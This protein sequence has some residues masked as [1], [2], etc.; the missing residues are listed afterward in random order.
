M[1][2]R[3]LP[4]E[5]LVEVAEYL[6]SDKTSLR[7]LALVCRQFRYASEGPLYHTINL[8][9]RHLDFRNDHD[10]L[11][12]V[13][14]TLLERPDLGEKVRTLFLTVYKT[15]NP[16][17]NYHENLILRNGRFQGFTK[18]CMTVVNRLGF[19]EKAWWV[20]KIRT[21]F[22]PAFGGILLALVPNVVRL[23]L[24]CGLSRD[25][26]LHY[27]GDLGTQMAI[28]ISE[29][30]G[31]DQI[32]SGIISSFK[33]VQQLYLQAPQLTKLAVGMGNIRILTLCMAFEDLVSPYVPYMNF[34]KLESLEVRILTEKV[35]DHER[36]AL[37]APEVFTQLLKAMDCPKL[38]KLS[39]VFT[40]TGRG[41]PVVD[42][43]FITDGLRELDSPWRPLICAC[44]LTSKVIQ[45]LLSQ[46][47]SISKP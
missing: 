8:R 31:T 19:T 23:Q 21:A 1:D 18:N 11:I 30:F 4:T 17:R 7:N 42:F 10:I 16:N 47:L 45:Y 14:R 43:N 20:Q 44:T 2:T 6:K 5:L 3:T 27:E 34:S 12:R 39:I 41:F 28:P 15:E 35:E 13:L 9:Y 22:E 24:E 32:P 29:L 26:D 37:G 25:P 46:A 38:K 36:E 33:K 40:T